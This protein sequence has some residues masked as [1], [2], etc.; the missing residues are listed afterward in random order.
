MHDSGTFMKIQFQVLF[1][2]LFGLASI[3]TI[4][5]EKIT[6]KW[7]DDNGE[8][9]YTERA[10]KGREYTKIRTYVDAK[11][12]STNHLPAVNKRTI[13]EQ[14]KDTYGTWRDE[15]CTIAIQNLDILNNASRISA[16]DGQGG[17]QLM[18]N[19]QK[20]EKISQMEQQRDKY[21]KPSEEK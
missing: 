20:Q 14:K 19:E 13:A 21:C 11:N 6:Y 1:V 7:T 15:N 10:P 17:K 9:H 2:I 18:S 8:T 16:D 4:A 3:D 5:A 12:A